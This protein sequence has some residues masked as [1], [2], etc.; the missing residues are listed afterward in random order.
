MERKRKAITLILLLCLIGIGM[1]GWRDYQASL[2]AEKNALELHG[3]VDVREIAVAF[4]ESDRIAELL[5]QEGDSVKKGELLARLDNEELKLNI[6]Q[7]E[8]EVASLQA[9]AD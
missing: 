9:A 8:A 5:V 7:T 3:N 1:A 2:Q 6:Q 4:R